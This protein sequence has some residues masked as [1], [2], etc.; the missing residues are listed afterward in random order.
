MWR[1]QN[2]WFGLSKIMDDDSYGVDGMDLTSEGAG[3]YWYLPPECFVVGKEPQKIS[4]KVE[5][6]SDGVTFFQCLCGRKPFGHNQPQQDILQ[7]NTILKATEVQFPVKPV[8]NS[9]A[10]AF[11][12][13]CLAYRKEGRCDV[14]QLV[15]D[16]YLLTHMRRSNASGSIHRAGPTAFPTPPSSSTITY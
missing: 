1:N 3:P 15:N 11:I 4:N 5:M 10:K 13:C 12:R 9:E 8:V 14:P 6:W 16:P 7:E 2:Y